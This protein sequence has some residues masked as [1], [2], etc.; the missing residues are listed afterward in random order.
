MRGHIIGH[1]CAQRYVGKSQSCMRGYR[2]LAAAKMELERVWER[3]IALQQEELQQAKAEE[4]M[5]V[6]REMPSPKPAHAPA[7]GA[8]SPIYINIICIYVW[9]S[10]KSAHRICS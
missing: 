8:V 7:P 3:E 4:T 9:M 2:K 5:E 10:R 1:E 6:A